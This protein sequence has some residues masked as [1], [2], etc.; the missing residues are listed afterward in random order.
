M[1]QNMV[2]DSLTLSTILDDYIQLPEYM[3]FE[4]INVNT[5]SNFGDYPIHIACVR[6]DITAIKRLLT[7]GAD[8]NT[9]GEHGYTPLHT[10]V[11]QGHISVVIL[12]LES[13][14][15]KTIKNANTMTALDLAYVLDEKEIQK[16]LE[17]F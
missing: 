2:D 9:S 4:K 8:I 12:L 15:D 3:G 17:Q 14:A 13:G 5:K 16:T 10:A 7:E 1:K 6:S 11:E